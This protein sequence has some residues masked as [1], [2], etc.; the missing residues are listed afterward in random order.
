MFGYSSYYTE[1]ELKAFGFR[2]LGKGVQFSRKTGVYKPNA[3]SLGDNARIDDFCVLSG[4]A[5]IEIG[6]YVH[7]GCYCALFG[8]AGITLRD[9]SGLSPR[10][11]VYSESDDY[12]GESLTNPTVPMAFKPTYHRGAVVIDRHVIVGTACT[13][14]PGVVLGEG[15]AIGAHSLVTKSCDPWNIY[16]GVPAKRLKR[17]SRRL[18]DLEKRMTA[19]EP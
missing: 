14:L 7:I 16:F 15:A 10:V 8:G 6:R 3:I 5:G 1:D 4:G 18:L 17:R 9:F 12:S 13:I 11:T 2:S 19:P